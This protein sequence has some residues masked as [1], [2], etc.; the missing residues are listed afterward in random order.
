MKPIFYTLLFLAVL[1]ACK[2][3]TQPGVQIFID[4]NTVIKTMQGR[5]GVSMHAIEDSLPVSTDG[6]KYHSWGGSVWGGNQPAE[7]S[8]RW[9]AIFK[10]ANWLGLDWCRVEIDHGMYEPE[11]GK[12]TF[13]NHEMRIL[14]R[15]LDYCQSRN[16]DVCFTEMWLDVKWLVLVSGYKLAM[17]DKGITVD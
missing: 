3:K 15:Y 10:H 11:K 17:G 9:N 14:Y 8:A 6:G 1:A 13:D 5:F 16:V 4:P 2:P 7:D 12:F